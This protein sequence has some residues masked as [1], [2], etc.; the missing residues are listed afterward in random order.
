MNR[1][2][3]SCG[4]LLVLFAL[5]WWKIVLPAIDITKLTTPRAW[6][7][8]AMPVLALFVIWAATLGRHTDE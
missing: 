8:A 2:A 6:L 5:L 7:L 3:T 4:V 1:N